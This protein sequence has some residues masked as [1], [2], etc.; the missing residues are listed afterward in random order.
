MAYTAA[1]LITISGTTG[2]LLGNP[3]QPIYDVRPYAE[4]DIDANTLFVAAQDWIIS[5]ECLGTL[6]HARKCMGVV[7]G[8]V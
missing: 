6:R 7:S 5:A 1:N 2:T 3:L 4:E 8:L